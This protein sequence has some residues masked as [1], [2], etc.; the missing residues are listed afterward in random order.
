MI[1]LGLIAGA[2]TTFSFLPQVLRTMRTGSAADLSAG[3]LVLFGLGV[4]G[5]C[6]YGALRSDLAIELTNAVT[7]VLVLT[8]VAAKLGATRE[9]ARR[10]GRG[11]APRRGR[12][13]QAT[14][15][16]PD[17]PANSAGTEVA[18]WRHA[19]LRTR[20]RGP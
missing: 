16:P 5:W 11:T 2:C 6:A 4:A 10:R 12:V 13:G 19:P 8:L 18:F 3:W 9:G 1:T 15:A 17:I 7:L 14:S 20:R